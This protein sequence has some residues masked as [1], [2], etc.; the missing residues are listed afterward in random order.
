[1]NSSEQ[2]SHRCE[3]RFLIWLRAGGGSAAHDY[4]ELVEKRRGAEARKRLDADAREQEVLENRGYYGEWK[5]E[6]K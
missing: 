5:Y 4:L 6:R 2:H 1:M 3:V